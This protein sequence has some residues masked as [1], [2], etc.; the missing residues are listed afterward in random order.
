MT[1]YREH[2]WIWIYVQEE[3]TKNPSVPFPLAANSKCK[4][5]LT[6]TE[7]ELVSQRPALDSIPGDYCEIYGR[8]RGME[9][10]S[11]LVSFRI[12]HGYHHSTVAPHSPAITPWH[13]RHAAHHYVREIITHAAKWSPVRFGRPRKGWSCFVFSFKVLADSA[14]GWTQNGGTWRQDV[15]TAMEGGKGI[16]SCQMW[17]LMTWRS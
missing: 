15:D 12:S 16:Y 13:V 5:T 9:Q 1:Q 7:S 2:L 17:R 3:G 11:G 10:V 6:C 8:P 14:F 4:V